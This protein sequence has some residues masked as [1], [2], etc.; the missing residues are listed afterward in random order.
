MTKRTLIRSQLLMLASTLCATLLLPGT[1]QAQRNYYVATE[2]GGYGV[3]DVIGVGINNRGDVVGYFAVPIGG[4]GMGFVYS[5]G[6]LT[7]I[8]PLPG[9]RNRMAGAINDSGTIVGMSGVPFLYEN[10]QMRDITLFFGGEAGQAMGINSSGQVV[11]F[12]TINMMLAGG[13][14]IYDARG[15]AKL[16]WLLPPSVASNW[17]FDIAFDINDSGAIIA[18]GSTIGGNHG[19]IIKDGTITDLGPNSQPKAINS[20]GDVL[21]TDGAGNALLWSGTNATY[22]P[23]SSTYLRDMNDSRQIVGSYGGVQHP[24]IYEQDTK[25]ELESLILGTN[26]AGVTINDAPCINNNGQIVVNGTSGYDTSRRSRSF[27]LTPVPI[28][29]NATNSSATTM[30]LTFW[31]MTNHTYTVQSSVEPSAWKDL[32]N[33]SGIAGDLTIPVATTNGPQRFYR[34][35]MD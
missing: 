5:N 6:H 15:A 12:V 24:F 29:R 16:E 3:N 28:I 32:T 34:V 14:F 21:G 8:G 4:T 7:P 10:G 17:R 2:I 20:A 23:L 26:T 1:L 30:N 22:L 25:F 11:G 13:A 9:R 18:Q 19:V 35:R 31:S 33:V 27:L